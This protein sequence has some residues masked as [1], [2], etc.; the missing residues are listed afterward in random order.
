MIKKLIIFC[1][2]WSFFTIFTHELGHALVVLIFGYPVKIISVGVGPSIFLPL[3]R[4]KLIVGL[5]PVSGFC[6]YQ[7]VPYQWQHIIIL[8]MGVVTQFAVLYLIYRWLKKNERWRKNAIS[9]FCYKY[10]INIA[11]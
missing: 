5:F 9:Y 2:L 4:F 11:F 10:A 1:Y 3:G 8:A 6:Q 7:G